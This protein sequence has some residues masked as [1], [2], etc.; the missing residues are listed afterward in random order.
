MNTD[1]PISSSLRPKSCDSR[2]ISVE[3]ENLCRNIDFEG[4]AAVFLAAIQESDEWLGT[5]NEI[6]LA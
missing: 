1:D 2:D 3:K 4:R 5:L 6:R